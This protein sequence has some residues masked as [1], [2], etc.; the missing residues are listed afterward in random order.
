MKGELGRAQPQIMTFGQDG[1]VN[2]L[3][4]DK[5]AVAAAGVEHAP[6]A[7][8]A[9]DNGM[10]PRAERV[11]E[12]HHALGATAN[13]V[14]R[15][16]IEQVIRAGAVADGHG[17]VEIHAIWKIVVRHSPGAKPYLSKSLGERQAQASL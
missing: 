9:A 1:F 14:V 13:A 7:A 11:G 2:F 4:V 8:L 3:A 12:H 10:Y 5:G 6:R 16:A 15:F 17:Q